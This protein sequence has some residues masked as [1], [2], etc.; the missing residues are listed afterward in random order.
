MEFKEKKLSGLK[1]T[2]TYRRWRPEIYLE[3][4]GILAD[5]VIRRRGEPAFQ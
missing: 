1:R 4:C 3:L 2:E 5:E